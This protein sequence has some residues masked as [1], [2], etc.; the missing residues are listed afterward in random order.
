MAEVIEPADK[1][2]AR[3]VNKI[4]EAKYPDINIIP[5]TD[6]RRA[7]IPNGNDWF[8]PTEIR[9]ELRERTSD[10]L[11]RIA[12]RLF[13]AEE[14]LINRILAELDVSPNLIMTVRQEWHLR[15]GFYVKI[16]SMTHIDN[17]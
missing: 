3:M 8:Y 17:N 10:P 6:G 7:R 5:L 11:H 13:S 14:N 15:D 4:R 1:L 2:L 16:M 12:S 9:L